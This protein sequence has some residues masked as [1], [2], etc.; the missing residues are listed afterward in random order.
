M[1]AVVTARSAMCVSASVPVSR[2]AHQLFG[3]ADGQGSTARQP[4]AAEE[5]LKEA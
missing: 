5:I 2:A 4:V 1:S 3:Q